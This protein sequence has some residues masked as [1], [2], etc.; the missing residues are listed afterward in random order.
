MKLVILLSSLLLS[1]CA[2]ILNDDLQN[3][4]VSSTAESIKGTIGGIPFHGPGIVQVRR[5]KADKIIIVDTPNCTKQTLLASSVD[6]KFF[7]NILSG[8][9][10]GSSTDYGSEK[11][12]KYQDQVI[13]PCK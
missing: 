8:G 13:I 9:T 11:M 3:I 12:W 5:S 10:F 1:A 2:T 6:P 4:S 7:I